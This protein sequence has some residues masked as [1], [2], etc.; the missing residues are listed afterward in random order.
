MTDE[1]VTY[2]VDTLNGLFDDILENNN[3]KMLNV[4]WFRNHCG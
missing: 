1:R 4:N 2:C 3:K